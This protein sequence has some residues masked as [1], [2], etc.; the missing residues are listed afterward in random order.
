MIGSQ[1]EIQQVFATSPE[2]IIYMDI[3]RIHE[4]RAQGQLSVETLRLLSASL[5]PLRS[6]EYFKATEKL[7]D[8]LRSGREVDDVFYE[9]YEALIDILAKNGYWLKP[10]RVLGRKHDSSE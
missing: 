7:I 6:P 2:V 9:W 8:D 4:L 10:R 3:Q 5:K 1:P